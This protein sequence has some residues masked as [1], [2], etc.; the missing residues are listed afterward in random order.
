MRGTIV[1]IYLG[2]DH[3]EGK[4]KDKRIFIHAA[5]DGPETGVIISAI[6]EKYWKNHFAGWGRVLPKSK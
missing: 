3:G 6:D 4:F 1:G 2:M 5:S